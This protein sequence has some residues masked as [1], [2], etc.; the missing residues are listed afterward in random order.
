[1]RWEEIDF[2]ESTWRLPRTKPNKK[3][4]IPLAPP[5]LAILVRRRENRTGESEW[6]FPARNPAEHAK[7]FR[8]E[9]E[10]L[11]K[12]AEL[13]DLRPHDVRRTLGSWMTKGGTPL[14]TVKSALG[15]ASIQTT[16][17]YSRLED[18][19]LRRA[20]EVTATR[21]LEAG[22]AAPKTITQ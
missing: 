12:R 14:P 15:H 21:M 9:W 7:R 20:L 11:V 8:S 10:R 22:D 3:Q 4:S 19:D 6:V 1:M 5:A 2:A 13:T 18:S 17:I 16:Q